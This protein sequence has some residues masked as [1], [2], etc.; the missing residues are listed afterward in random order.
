[1]CTSS[2]EDNDSE[3]LET[4]ISLNDA[5]RSSLSCAQH[6]ST[7]SQ[8]SAFAHPEV[9]EVA[10]DV[11]DK[12][13]EDAMMKETAA[14]LASLSDVILSPIK[15]PQVNRNQESDDICSKR[16]VRLKSHWN[17]C[18]ITF[19]YLFHRK[20]RLLQGELARSIL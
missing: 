14:L 5:A 4:P 12:D 16:E 9:D 11:E 2:T 18:T 1:M 17:T 3:L 19:G 20:R 7:T 8:T 15:T 6:C 13:R 10:T